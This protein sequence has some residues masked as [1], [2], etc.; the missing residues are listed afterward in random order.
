MEMNNLPSGRDRAST[1]TSDY[2][3]LTPN[4]QTYT[5]VSEVTLPGQALSA[6]TA[7]E[8]NLPPRRW[9]QQQ[10]PT[11][12]A[13]PAA[14]AGPPPPRRWTQQQRPK[15]PALQAYFHKAPL[16]SVDGFDGSNIDDEHT[17]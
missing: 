17:A 16:R 2:V 7:F 8:E 15:A 14:E 6:S 1:K 12:V 11:A 4:H 5:H 10:R 9:T 13:A 3:G